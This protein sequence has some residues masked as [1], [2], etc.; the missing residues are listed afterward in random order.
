MVTEIVEPKQ[1]ELKDAK[2]Q[3]EE[4]LISKL[5]FEKATKKAEN[6]KKELKMVKALKTLQDN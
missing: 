5:Q 2:K 3:V 1:L 6:I 4:E